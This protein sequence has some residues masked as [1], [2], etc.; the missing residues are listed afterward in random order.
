MSGKPINDK[1]IRIYMSLRTQGK[2]QVTAAAK[3][4]ISERSGRRIESGE[5]SASHKVSR[6]WRTRKD[7]FEEIWESEVVPLLTGSP[8][9]QPRTLF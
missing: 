2:E 5:L 7:P 9:L 8:E 6:D 1:Q 4:G 3:A